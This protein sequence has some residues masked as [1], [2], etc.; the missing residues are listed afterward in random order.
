M[1]RKQCCAPVQGNK[2][3]RHALP[4]PSLSQNGVTQLQLELLVHETGWLG[5]STAGGR[6]LG[7]P[8]NHAAAEPVCSRDSLAQCLFHTS[9]MFKPLLLF[10]DTYSQNQIL[11]ATQG[12]FSFG[13][14]F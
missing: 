14:A 10:F 7:I 2:E 4:V 3:R 6:G 1:K 8:D 11:N 13:S 12:Y 9:M 5:C